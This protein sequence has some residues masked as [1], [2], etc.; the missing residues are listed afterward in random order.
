MFLALVAILFEA[1]QDVFLSK[2]VASEAGR[3]GQQEI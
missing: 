2:S 3:K 1:I